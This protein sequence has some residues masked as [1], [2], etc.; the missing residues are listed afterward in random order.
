MVLFKDKRGIDSLYSTI[1][2]IILNLMF[3]VA[4]FLVVS[5]VESG[6][7]L[8]EQA[9]AK[10]IVLLIDGAKPGTMVSLNVNDFNKFIEKKLISENEIISINANK[11][12]TRLSRGKGYSFEYFSDYAIDSSLRHD[13]ENL[14]L[15]IFVKEGENGK[16]I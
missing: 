11:V 7:S 3:F 2:F 15:D 13:K 4:M 9:Y 8:Y 16:V 14:Y 10:Q 1:I 12:N 6:A 5:R